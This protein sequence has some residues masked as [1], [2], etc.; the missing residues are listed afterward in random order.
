M[1]FCYYL[2]NRKSKFT[3]VLPRG[4]ADSVPLIFNLVTTSNHVN[5][6]Q[7]IEIDPDI[8]DLTY[9]LL[10]FYFYFQSFTSFE[11]LLLPEIKSKLDL[12]PNSYLDAFSELFNVVIH[13]ALQL[14]SDFKDA[15][16]R[17]SA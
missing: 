3:H 16:L 15:L 2:R 8:S 12:S 13:D 6:A 4:I 5:L 9:E 10:I 11:C 17:S 1:A 7:F 14:N